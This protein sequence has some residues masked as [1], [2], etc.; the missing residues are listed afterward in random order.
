M[1]PKACTV[2][3]VSVVIHCLEAWLLLLLLQLLLGGRVQCGCMVLGPP[4]AH[5][6]GVRQHHPQPCLRLMHT[7]AHGS[8]YR[9]AAS[10]DSAG[11][12]ATAITRSAECLAG[13]SAQSLGLVGMR[14]MPVGVD[15]NPGGL[16][17]VSTL[18]EW[19]WRFVLH[20]PKVNVH[21]IH[22]HRASWQ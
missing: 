4:P 13:S 12:A 1:G 5:G 10:G 16:S 6:S 3:A 9:G 17:S 11:L 7:A 2:D 8:A 20:E 22:I 21:A 15:G 14:L 19:A 18:P